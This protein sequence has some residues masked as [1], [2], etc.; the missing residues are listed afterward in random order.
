[1]RPPTLPTYAL[2]LLSLLAPTLAQNKT[3]YALTA[4]ISTIPPSPLPSASSAS[5]TATPTGTPT[6][7]IFTVFPT[8]SAGNGT[9]NGT[10]Y[11]VT[12]NGTAADSGPVLNP[13]GIDPAYGILGALLIL[14]HLPLLLLGPKLRLYTPLLLTS[15]ILSITTLIL[16]LHFGVEP[17]LSL[18]PPDQMLRGLYLLACLVAGGV[19]AG[20]AA[21][22]REYAEWGCGAVAG[23]ALAC[24]IEALRSGGVV[25]GDWRWLLFAGLAVGGFVLTTVKVIKMACLVGATAIVGAS[26]V[27]L[28]ID[29]FTA[30]GLKEFYVANL[31]FTDLFP[32]LPAG[33]IP[34]LQP[35]VVELSLIAALVL[36]SLAIQLR[37]VPLLKAA[38][39]RQA[40][41]R[42]AAA[43][44]AEEEK[45][46]QGLEGE[47]LRAEREEWEGRHGRTGGTGTGTSAASSPLLDDKKDGRPSSQFSLLPSFLPYSGN[48]TSPGEDA[49]H[50]RSLSISKLQNGPDYFDTSKAGDRRSTSLGALPALNLGGLTEPSGSLGIPL[51]TATATST[52]SLPSPTPTPSPKPLS[53]RDPD[54]EA[55]V[56]DLKEKMALL[57]EIRTIKASIG[58]LKSETGSINLAREESRG[59][60]IS[61]A[62]HTRSV[63]GITLDVPR[64]DVRRSSSPTPAVAGPSSP[65]AGLG[66]EWDAYLKQR[67]LY[68]PPPFPQQQQRAERIKQS[69]HVTQAIEG[70]RRRESM[71]ELGVVP[72]SSPAPAQAQTQGQM[73]RGSSYYDSVPGLQA[74]RRQSAYDMPVAAGPHVP[75]PQQRAE[76]QAQAQ[77]RLPHR[78]V[79]PPPA[80]SETSATVSPPSQPSAPFTVLPDRSPRIASPAPPLGSPA[81]GPDTN[82]LSPR[83]VHPPAHARILT[84]GQLEARHRAALSG[85]Q[86]PVSQMLLATQ[87]G[88]PKGHKSE[89]SSSSGS[90]QGQGRSEEEQQRRRQ[91]RERQGKERRRSTNDIDRLAE[92][93]PTAGAGEHKRRGTGTGEVPFPSQRQAGDRDK[94]RARR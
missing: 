57:D 87:A 43:R 17:N 42:A 15:H 4:V 92:R 38:K 45:A 8:L 48:A 81:I 86:R 40:E 24:W 20:L 55:A 19:G 54:T 41:Q 26:G 50:S 39:E 84:T 93:S 32:Q 66:A 7:I 63:S 56:Q 60:H 18:H 74:P 76:S 83:P 2:L 67:K 61:D 34:L 59:T 94:T 73:G 16:I 62:S 89:A 6:T 5:L 47:F 88:S 9:S 22:W 91:A 49:R 75:E 33:P 51:A 21:L 44:D 69:D 25:Q 10:G 71:L 65:T 30:V 80:I 82:V 37:V 28:G 11:N 72:A 12:N 46:R 77:Q 1:M 23:F 13:I 27:M 53:Y 64:G 90:G 85:M 79:S 58:K 78:I 52:P 68:V 36:I 31:G 35:V 14:S 70:R 3:S 29:C